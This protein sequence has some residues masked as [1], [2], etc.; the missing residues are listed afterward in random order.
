MI[1][2]EGVNHL[3]RIAHLESGNHGGRPHLKPLAKIPAVQRAGVDRPRA[4]D[5]CRV[6]MDCPHRAIQQNVVAAIRAAGG[7]VSYDWD[8]RTGVVVPGGS[9]WAPGWIVDLVGVDYFGHVTDVSLSSLSKE[10]DAAIAQI[11]AFPVCSD[12]ISVD[13]TLA[14][15]GWRI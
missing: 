8:S 9:P 5:R 1:L 7:G 4:C 13:G 6:G 15:P 2:V 14:T 3:Q 11:G 12:F 10:T